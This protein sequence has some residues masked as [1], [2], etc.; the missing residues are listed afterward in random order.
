[1]AKVYY[2]RMLLGTSTFDAV[3]PKYQD[4]VMELGK[5]DVRKGRLTKEQYEMLFKVEYEE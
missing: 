3:N 5:A 4:A 1:M 2:N